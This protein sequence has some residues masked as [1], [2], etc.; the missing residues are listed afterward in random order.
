MQVVFGLNSF[1][2]KQ[3]VQELITWDSFK[4]TNLNFL[5]TGMSGSGKTYQL[6]KII[7]NLSTSALK[8]ND[9]DFK[10]HIFDVHGDIRCLNESLVTYSENSGFGINPLILNTDPEYGGVRKRIQSFINTISKSTSKLGPR[11]EAVIASL[12]E[13]LY[14]Y[15][16]FYKDNPNT[17][18]LDSS[19]GGKDGVVFI[20]VPFEKRDAAKKIGAWWN[21]GLKSWYLPANKYIP[22]EPPSKNKEKNDSCNESDEPER[23]PI[24][25]NV[26]SETTKVYPSLEDAAKFIYSKM[27]ESFLG[28]GRDG[29]EALQNFHKVTSNYNKVLAKLHYSDS[30][31]AYATDSEL[32]QIER[33]GNLVRNAVESYLQEKVTE[34]TLK[35]AILYTSLDSLTSIHQRIKN[36]LESGV[37]RSTPAP[38]DPAMPVHRHN[39]RPLSHEEQRMFILFSLERIFEE[40]V[41]RGEVKPGTIRYVIVVDEAAKFFDKDPRNPLNYI[42]LEGRKFGICLICSSQSPAH[43]SEDFLGSVA[44]K[45]ILGLD[46][47]HWEN[48]RT[49]LKINPERMEYIIPQKEMLV[50]IKQNGANKNGWKGVSLTQNPNS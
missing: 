3:G 20:D 41:Q 46:E 25:R 23:F 19:I 11:Q 50:Q 24:N 35:D 21:P 38:L 45:L 18:G 37:F 44:T 12:L 27:E 47:M 40:A 31:S 32:A 42:A 8:S 16:G 6:R 7:N 14:S 34:K 13:D 39:L 33:A 4:V 43:F 29:M 5:V 49:K 30:G 1:K 22:P 17:W 15:Y 28:I 26:K 9:M 10:A 36:M 2:L 48:S